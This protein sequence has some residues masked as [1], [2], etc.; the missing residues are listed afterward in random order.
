MSAV[1]E[2]AAGSSDIT[3]DYNE[4]HYSKN[5]ETYHWA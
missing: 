4:G 2:Y 3:K 1:C 5:K